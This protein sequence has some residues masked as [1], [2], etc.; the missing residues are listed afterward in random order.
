MK[1]NWFYII[2][3][4][5]LA[6]ILTVLIIFIVK[7]QGM[8][9]D[10]FSLEG[11]WK[12]HSRYAQPVEDE[13]MVFGDGTVADY[14]NGAEAFNGEFEWI[15]DGASIKIEALNKEFYIHKK[16]DNI[17]VL[18]EPGDSEA[19]KLRWELFRVDANPPSTANVESL[20]GEWTVLIH[21]DGIVEGEEVVFTSD[22]LI[23]K[24]DGATKVD[25]TYTKLTSNR[26]YIEKIA[27][28]FDIYQLDEDTVIFVEVGKGLWE[29]KAK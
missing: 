23:L 9:T 20:V 15:N 12:V 18:V 24:V 19:T 10:T 3:G 21:N 28:T 11:T 27:T 5:V 8:D 13:Y 1:K 22:S 25:A 7:T 14:R 26:I 29:L 17:I 16:T 6:I 2:G 4:V